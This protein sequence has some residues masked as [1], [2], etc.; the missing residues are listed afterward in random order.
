MKGFIM[1]YPI[2]VVSVFCLVA[3]CCATPAPEKCKSE[4]DSKIQQL[5][6]RIQQLEKRVDEL[7]P[8]IGVLP[9]E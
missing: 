8:G 3:G 6:K 4:M 1:K 7:H 9:L 2:L 5:E